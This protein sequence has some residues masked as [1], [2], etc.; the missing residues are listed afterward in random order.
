MATLFTVRSQA[1]ANTLPAKIDHGDRTTD[2]ALYV[3]IDS[4]VKIKKLSISNAYFPIQK[5]GDGELHIEELTLTEF[6][7]DG[8]RLN[9]NG[10]R[11]DKLTVKD[12]TPT[13]P[14][15]PLI[16]ERLAGETDRPQRSR[17]DKELLA[18]NEGTITDLD[19]LKWTLYSC[20]TVQR[21]FNRS[22][23]CQDDSKE[24]L[25]SQA[26]HMDVFQA[27]R[28]VNRPY[29][30][31]SDRSI[32]EEP[33]KLNVGDQ[34]NIIGAIAY[35][36]DLPIEAAIRTYFNT[37]VELPLKYDDKDNLIIET[38]FLD[39]PLV[40][41][42]VAGDR[43]SGKDIRLGAV[44][45]SN[46]LNEAKSRYQSFEE[47]VRSLRSIDPYQIGNVR[48]ADAKIEKIHERTQI[49]MLSE[50][51]K[52]FNY[53]IGYDKL[54]VKTAY[55]YFFSAITLSDSTIGNRNANGVKLSPNTKVRI[56]EA[57]PA[58]TQAACWGIRDCIKP[59]PHVTSNVFL[60]GMGTDH[61][62]SSGVG[63]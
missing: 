39:T 22:L 57:H 59:S 29:T 35:E 33:V 36:F 24:Y 37:I 28:P 1:D 8:I 54:D 23:T 27:Y 55:P 31:D 45:N 26:D 44:K 2:T 11:I 25:V 34:N 51:N 43:F 52:Y 4:Y 12:N 50:V 41:D 6:G 13:R 21:K 60:L 15:S 46:A 30:E 38:G 42:K 17:V 63:F 19:K 47:K 20:E 49:F 10:L 9:G 16:L 5:Y 32:F 18:K 7:G 53:R 58:I 56:G 48:I 62:V 61:E 14:Y 3:D 40:F